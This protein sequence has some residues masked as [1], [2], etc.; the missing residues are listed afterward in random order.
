MDFIHY[1][2]QVFKSYIFNLSQP[3]SSN[4]TLERT[5]KSVEK[6]RILAALFFIFLSF[7]AVPYDITP[8]STTVNKICGSTSALYMFTLVS[9]GIIQLL[10]FKIARPVDIFF[11]MV[12]ARIVH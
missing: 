3:S 7:S 9:N 1:H 10:R 11:E 4:K 8:Y 12:N 2:G 6:V 5:S